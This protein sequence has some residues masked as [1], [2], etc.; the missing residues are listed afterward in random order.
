MGRRPPWV[1]LGMSGAAT[2]ANCAGKTPEASI[3]SH[4]VLTRRDLRRTSVG[5]GE[6]AWRRGESGGGFAQLGG[7]KGR[8]RCAGRVAREGVGDEVSVV[9]GEIVAAPVAGPGVR[10]VGD[11][12][13][14]AARE[15]GLVAPLNNGR[16][17]GVAAADVG[18]SGAAP[19]PAQQ[20]RPSGASCRRWRA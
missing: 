9:L 4:R 16:L 14:G 7:G 20:W 17:P 6:R 3:Q 2:R 18:V 13:V 1:L 10:V 5:N 19:I 12:E 11:D 15:G 8:E